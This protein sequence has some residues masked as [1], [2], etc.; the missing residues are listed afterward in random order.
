[1]GALVLQTAGRQQAVMDRLHELAD[2]G[3]P[4]PQGLGPVARSTALG[5]AMTVA[6]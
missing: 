4:A 3:V 6:P 2:A 1:M 5:L